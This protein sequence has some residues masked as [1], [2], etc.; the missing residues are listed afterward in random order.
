MNQL[1]EDLKEPVSI[2][3][4]WENNHNGNAEGHKFW[5]SGSFGPDVWNYLHVIDKIQ[6]RM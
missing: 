5:L 4:F 3:G 2:E 6:P 1:V